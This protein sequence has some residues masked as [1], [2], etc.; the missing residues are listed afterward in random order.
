MVS[1]NDFMKMF[2]FG[3]DD[4]VKVSAVKLQAVLD[5][6]TKLEEDNEKL[7]LS[8]IEY[9][10]VVNTQSNEIKRLLEREEYLLDV[11]DKQHEEIIRYHNESKKLEN[12]LHEVN[13]RLDKAL[14]KAKD[15][16]VLRDR[17]DVATV[18]YEYRKNQ[19]MLDRLT[20]DIVV[21]I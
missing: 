6:L 9:K 18:L 2:G 10:E 12:S 7:K 4:T 14:H 5:K 21:D 1:K 3:S 16:D 8:N 17:L 13:R 20:S 15:R 11:N 19:N